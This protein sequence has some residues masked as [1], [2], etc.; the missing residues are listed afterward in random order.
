LMSSLNQHG[1]DK[2]VCKWVIN[3]IENNPIY[4]YY[5]DQPGIIQWVEDSKNRLVEKT[6]K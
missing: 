4:D 3:N 6:S 5:K 2:S 1:R